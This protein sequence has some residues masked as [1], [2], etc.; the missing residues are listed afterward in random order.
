MDAFHA[1]KQNLCFLCSHID[2]GIFCKFSP[3]KGVF[4]SPFLNGLKCCLHV[5]D[6]KTN[7]QALTVKPVLTT[8]SEIVRLKETFN[9]NVPSLGVLYQVT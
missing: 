4:K 8:V 1:V 7:R 3:C 6:A 2:T 5:S 9:Q